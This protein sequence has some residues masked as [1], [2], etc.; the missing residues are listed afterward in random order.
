MVRTATAPQKDRLDRLSSLLGTDSTTLLK[1]L[2]SGTTL[3]SPAA[4]E[5]VDASTLT[6]VLQSGDLYDSYA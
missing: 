3:T 4:A 1:Q 2:T 5:G 6:S